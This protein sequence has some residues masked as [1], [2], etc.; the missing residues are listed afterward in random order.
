MLRGVI[1]GLFSIT[2]TPTL[3]RRGRGRNTAAALIAELRARRK[4]AAAL[5]AAKGKAAATFETEL[6]VCGVLA[7]TLR[8]LHFLLFRLAVW[9]TGLGF[10]FLAGFARWPLLLTFGFRA[11]DFRFETCA[12]LSSFANR[13]A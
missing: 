4:F 3:S 9:R 7:T 10:V 6:G 11:A 2:L 8:T 1:A 12:F 13:S 5:R